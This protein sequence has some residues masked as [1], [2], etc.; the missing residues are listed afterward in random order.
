MHGGWEL[1]GAGVAVGAVVVKGGLRNAL[2]IERLLL[3]RFSFG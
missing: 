3:E 1:V 2:I